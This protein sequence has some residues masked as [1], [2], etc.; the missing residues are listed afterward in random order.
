MLVAD[1]IERGRDAVHERLAA[2]EGVVGQHVRSIGEMLA[3]AEADLEME[4]TI[5]AEQAGAVISPSPGTSI[6]GS[7]LSTRSCWLLRSLCPLDRP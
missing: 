2:D 1:M 7:R 4:R 3:R 5:L 6:C